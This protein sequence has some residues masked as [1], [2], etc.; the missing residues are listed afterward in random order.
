MEGCSVCECDEKEVPRNWI[1]EQ[2][3]AKPHTT[4][5][6]MTHESPNSA[7]L[8]VTNVDNL[9]SKSNST[10]Y[11]EYL[12]S[13]KAPASQASG[14]MKTHSSRILNV[15][16]RLRQQ[17]WRQG[18]LMQPEQAGGLQMSGL[19]IANAHNED[20]A[21]DSDY[22]S[23]FTRH[24]IGAGKSMAS[25]ANITGDEITCDTHA[26]NEN[27]MIE[28]KSSPSSACAYDPEM[29]SWTDMVEDDCLSGTHTGDNPA[30]YS[31]AGMVRVDFQTLNFTPNI[32]LFTSL[33]T[34]VAAHFI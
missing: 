19:H 4:L 14:P 11:E 21:P 33:C 5:D 29:H 9:I 32:T 15:D 7:P 10:N 23:Y 22:D 28:L 12:Y 3:N 20:A 34:S 16:N 24:S 2:G 30:T 17:P 26:V 6:Q 31:T 8:F 1:D 13:F 18:Q 25:E 27:S